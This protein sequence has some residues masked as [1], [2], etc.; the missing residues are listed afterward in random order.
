MDQKVRLRAAD[1]EVV[2]IES[3][4]MSVGEC[5]EVTEDD[6]DLRLHNFG[7]CASYNLGHYF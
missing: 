6:C 4:E 2:R 1:Q 7:F 3:V 5:H